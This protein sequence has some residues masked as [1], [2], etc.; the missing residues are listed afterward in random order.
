MEKSYLIFGIYLTLAKSDGVRARDIAEKYEI[1]TRSVYRY[2]DALCEAGLPVLS[3][4]G[5]GGGFSLPKGYFLEKG[6]LLA[7]DRKF[8]LE[9]IEKNKIYSN[10]KQLSRIRHILS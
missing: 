6:C 4:K 8:I 10:P 3:K 5:H 9:S 2:V 7:E 1:S